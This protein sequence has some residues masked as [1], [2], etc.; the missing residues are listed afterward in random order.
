[1]T[2]I[3]MVCAGSGSRVPTLCPISKESCPGFCIFADI[4]DSVR[5]GVVLF[6]LEQQT[7]A[8]VNSPARE[9]FKDVEQPI[10]Y[11]S[12][13]EL[14][15]PKGIDIRRFEPPLVPE[16]LHL[17]NHLLGY[18]LYQSRGYAWV[19]LRDITEKARLES[20][21]EAVEL[22]NSI[23]FVFS[24][25]RHELGNPINSVKAALS[26]LRANLERFSREQIADYLDRMLVEVGRVEHL[27]RSMKSFSMFERTKPEPVDL[28][29]FFGDYLR[30]IGSEAERRDIR[31]T[32]GC[33]PGTWALCDQRALQQVFLNLFANAADALEGREG[34]EVRIE[35]GRADGLVRIRFGDNGPGLSEE[36]KEDLFKPFYTSKE[37]GTGLG[38]VITR[39]LLVKMQGTIAMESREG[40]G[41]TAVITLP[42]AE[43]PR[44]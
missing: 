38:L 14:L 20:I 42:A 10:S 41:T 29:A 12:M 35:T 7:L 25:V 16:P 21:A 36:Q 23:G 31:L 2:S 34:S 1:M 44:A 4:M 32:I 26:V 6:N 37:N 17:N 22:M 30:L 13:L 19:F 27:L 9:M 33:P 15:V 5:L 8:F 28:G 39:K 18:T 24:A 3:P 43:R 11:A 40:Q